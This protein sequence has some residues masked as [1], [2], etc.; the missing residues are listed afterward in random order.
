[1]FL[2]FTFQDMS[3]RSVKQYQ[4]T[5]W[6]EEPGAVPSNGTGLIDLIGQVQ[7]WQMNSGNRPIIVH[8]R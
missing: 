4:F 1:M 3:S 5:G 2:C 7:R 8:C 6:P